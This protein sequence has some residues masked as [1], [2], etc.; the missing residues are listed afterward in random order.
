MILVPG[1]WDNLTEDGRV[2]GFLMERVRN[3]RHADP[4]DLEACQ[5]TL[6]RLH[7]L[8]IRHGDS[9]SI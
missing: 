8:G 2:I 9:K 5:E 6:P 3:A 4:Q 7:A 1:S